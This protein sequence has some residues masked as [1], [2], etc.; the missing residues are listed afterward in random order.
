MHYKLTTFG[1]ITVWYKNSFI[2]FQRKNR[3]FEKR[4]M[5][6]FQQIPRKGPFEVKKF[7]IEIFYILEHPSIHPSS[8]IWGKNEIENCEYQKNSIILLNTQSVHH[9]LHEIYFS[10]SASSKFLGVWD[11]RAAII[12]KSIW[13]ISG[14]LLLSIFR[15]FLQN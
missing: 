8:I 7:W 2:S 10:V 14:K 13:H 5:Q 15:I 4:I 12:P 11:A 6:N 9:L 1:V 3:V